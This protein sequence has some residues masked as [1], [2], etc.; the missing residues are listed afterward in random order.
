M[1][2]KSSKWNNC[3]ISKNFC[4][5]NKFYLVSIGNIACLLEKK[6]QSIIPQEISNILF[7]MQFIATIPWFENHNIANVKLII[8]RSEINR[9]YEYFHFDI[10]HGEEKFA[11]LNN[12]T[13]RLS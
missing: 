10:C 5:W 7:C 8:F 6:S 11:I 12:I 13:V 9:I 3:V 1:G 4:L 2:K